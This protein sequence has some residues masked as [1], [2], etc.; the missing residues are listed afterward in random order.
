[1]SIRKRLLPVVG[2]GAVAML[3]GGI[4]VSQHAPHTDAAGPTHAAIGCANSTLATDIAFPAVAGVITGTTQSTVTAGTV[5]ALLSV[6]TPNAVVE[7]GAVFEDD[8]IAPGVTPTIANGLATQDADPTSVDGGSITYSLTS[9]VA[10]I[11]ES[12]SVTFSVGCG[13]T[14][15]PEGCQGGVPNTGNGATATS[16]S[17]NPAN[18][19]HVALR[20]GATFP[21]INAASPVITLQASYARFASIPNPFGP[22]TA[23]TNTATIGLAV[24]SYAST[25]TPNPATIPATATAA[26][27]GSTLTMALF[28][29]TPVCT[30][31][32]GVTTLLPLTASSPL[33]V[34]GGNT[35]IATV[36]QYTAGA[37]SGVVTFTTSSGVFGST[38]L[39]AG[40]GQQIYSV[41]CGPVPATVPTILIPTLGVT[42][43][44][45]LTSCQTATATLF[46]GGAAGTAVVV[47][48]F[49]GDFTGGTTQATT[50]VQLSAAP[51][52]TSLSRG[53]NE[54]I[55]GPS[56]A[57][58]TP[59]STVAG[60]VQ[61][62][63][64]VVSIWQFN[65]STHAFQAGY[66]NP[67]GAPTDFSTTGPGQSLFI[68][69]SGAGT[70]P[71]Q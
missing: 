21:L 27:Q 66:F 41:H 13:S 10:M 58:N 29:L 45:A 33:V 49:I 70:F 31:I 32:S 53:C 54:V 42:T 25:L 39:T 26:S 35:G 61:P 30:T 16:V 6:T 43:T 40:G 24:P 3:L 37:E 23:S 55:T 64:I 36:Q 18:L 57:A 8:A 65:N 60:L 71:T 12:N 2:V 5:P 56:V 62:A 1:L 34:C 68:C 44:F 20:P 51:L 67:A 9:G 15:V 19:V 52:T 28:H 4:V 48:N 46:G 22:A 63:G 11:L 47:A 59:V 7:C 50:S 17:V 69:V 14:T 38:S